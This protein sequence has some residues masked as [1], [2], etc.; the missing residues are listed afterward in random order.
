MYKTIST[1]FDEMVARHR[2][3]RRG[4]EEIGYKKAG[5]KD[6]SAGVIK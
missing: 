4:E 6:V 5:P 3:L 2:I 1:Q